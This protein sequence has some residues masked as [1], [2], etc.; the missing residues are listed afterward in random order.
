MDRYISDEDLEKEYDLRGLKPDPLAQC[1]VNEADPLFADT[2][3]NGTHWKNAKGKWCFVDFD[4]WDDEP[5][6]R[7]G[8]DDYVGYDYWWFGGVRKQNLSL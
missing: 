2:R 1:A 7:V 5:I 3:P 8:Q 6:V 4:R